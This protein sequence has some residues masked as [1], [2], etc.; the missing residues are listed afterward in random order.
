M[1]YLISLAIMLILR[2]FKVRQAF[3]IGLN[4]TESALEQEVL[5]GIVTLTRLQAGVRNLGH[6][7]RHLGLVKSRLE[8]LA[9]SMAVLGTVEGEPK[10]LPTVGNRR[11]VEH[12]V[13][14]DRLGVE[15]VEED[16]VNVVGFLHEPLECLEG[17]DLRARIVEVPLC[18]RI[19]L[20]NL[21]ELLLNASQADQNALSVFS[22]LLLVTCD[23]A[24]KFLSNFE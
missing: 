1:F 12:S 19:C 8:S 7:L 23:E 9:E 3:N 4:L 22:G 13:Y 6:A 17:L 11:R 14:R 5:C 20:A 24:E 2:F 18:R 21:A 16:R 15:Q 10:R